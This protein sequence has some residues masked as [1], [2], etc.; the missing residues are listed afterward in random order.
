MTPWPKPIEL[1]T[2]S[3]RMVWYVN[4]ISVKLLKTVE[5]G[6]K[7][8]TMAFL[9]EASSFLLV[10]GWVW[11]CMCVVSRAWHKLEPSKCLLIEWMD[12]WQ[13]DWWID[14][15]MDDGSLPPKWPPMSLISWDLCPCVASSNTKQELTL[16]LAEFWGRDNIW[17]VT[18]GNKRHR[19]FH[20]GP[21]GC[22][23]GRKP[24]TMLWGHSSS[25]LERLRWKGTETS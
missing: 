2:L 6:R 12:R 17:R 22:C 5:N 16:W 25:S 18:L 21:L 1:Y 8:P 19:S 7:C 15:W 4:C 3:E 10:L 9:Y 13:K 14:G 24:A 20:F 23:L 11:G